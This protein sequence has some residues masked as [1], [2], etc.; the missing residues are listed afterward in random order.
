[1][2]AVSA[3]ERTDAS[4]MIT[5]PND[6]DASKWTTSRNE[7]WAY[8]LYYVGNNGLSGF[9]F[10]PSQ[11]QNLLFLA[12]YD[13]A[14]PPFSKPCGT[15]NCVLPYL[16]KI[17]DGMLFRRSRIVYQDLS[18]PVNAI[19]LLTNGISF[20]I[21]AILLLFIGAWADYGYWRSIGL[22]FL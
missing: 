9:N 14:F 8:Y 18:Y 17:R 2:E 7:L 13:P 3:D 15:G 5:H 20:A 4:L 22:R 19:V 10:G 12:G 21:Q 11:F 1:M 6:H 16:G